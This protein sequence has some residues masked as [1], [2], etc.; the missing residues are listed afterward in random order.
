MSPSYL[1]NVAENDIINCKFGKDCI[2]LIFAF[3]AFS[4]GRLSV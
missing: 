3:L 4:Q 1:L 2:S